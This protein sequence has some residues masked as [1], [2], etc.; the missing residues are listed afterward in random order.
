MIR[1]MFFL[2]CE[3]LCQDITRKLADNPSMDLWQ[4]VADRWQRICQFL[5]LL[6]SFD[7]VRGGLGRLWDLLDLWYTSPVPEMARFAKLAFR[8]KVTP[9]MQKCEVELLLS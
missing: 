6:P 1:G 7:L 3:I 2:I 5:A 4:E 8:A 9:S